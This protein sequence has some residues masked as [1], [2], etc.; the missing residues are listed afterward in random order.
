[1]SGE[2][3]A[4]R[5]VAE[6]F[7]DLQSLAQSQGALHQISA[8]V[9]RDWLV[10]VDM[11]LGEVVD[12]PGARWS[13]SKLNKNEL[14][15]LLGLMVQSPTDQTFA[16]EN[17]VEDFA[18]RAD[19]LLREFHDRV[20][21]DGGISFNPESADPFAASTIGPVA[22]EA[23]Y[24]GADSFYLHQ[25]KTYAL[26]RYQADDEWLTANCGFDSQQMTR[27]AT[28]IIDRVLDQMAHA[29]HINRHEQALPPHEMT[30]SL[31]IPKALLQ[32]EFGSVGDS[33]IGKFSTS[34]TSANAG[35]TDPFKVNDVAIAP[36]IDIGEYLYVANAY[37]LM[38]SVY[39]SPF[40]WMMADKAYAATSAKH[41]GAFL[42]RTSASILRSVFGDENVYENV[43]I[44]TSAKTIAGE[45]DV[46]VIYG[47][48]VLIGQA[49]SKR[50]TQKARAGDSDALAADFKGA[51]QDPYEQALACASL[52]K[53]GAACTTSDG[54]AIEIPRLPITFPLVI[55][56]DPFPAVT[57]LSGAMLKQA[58]DDAP[59][60]WDLAVLDCVARV[61][62]SPVDLLFY[63]RC[64]AEAFHTMRSDSEYN[65]LGFHLRHKLVLPEEADLVQIDR[66]YASAIDDFM[67]AGDV[68]VS[69]APPD[70][71]IDKIRIPI[72]SDLLD[73]L[74]RSG[75]AA[76]L[77]ALDLY[78][79]SSD[80]LRYL[81]DQIAAIRAEIKAGKPLKAVSIPTRSGGLTYLVVQNRSEEAH[82]AA[83]AF[84]AKHK[85]DQ[86]K[87]RWSVVVD[88][89]ATLNP[90]D[91]LFQI[92]TPWVE[93]TDE[94][95]NS[96][97]IST[98]FKRREE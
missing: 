96:R 87:D 21:A 60:I 71:V 39:E 50:V 37:R 3:T 91:A 85:Y 59:V 76:A 75:P 84:G 95:E 2:S 56:S 57:F 72:I 61:L 63:L 55:L 9:F 58:S 42:E 8:I 89:V 98:V 48:F 81:A 31:L 93:D 52:I 35:F 14:M 34:A 46:L 54:A 68:G 23:I 18:D 5:T 51:M 38:E 69:R 6:I 70:S 53:S 11:K 1:M 32:T 19:R 97:R 25:L 12:A 90:I 30:N 66:D 4:P 29:G 33:F 80:S 65:L 78:D 41:R 7:A 74:R 92:A 22:K 15:L 45:I 28:F 88:C 64:R 13:T 43:T 20:S 83:K 44:K 73:E 16:F 94:A 17:G 40:Y 24:Y 86:R 26:P 49:K 62:P 82:I 77:V 27:I 36:L 47:P 10:T 67:I 79:L